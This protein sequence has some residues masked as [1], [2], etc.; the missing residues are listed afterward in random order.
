MI[1]ALFSIPA[2]FDSSMV[3]AF[4]MEPSSVFPRIFHTH[5]ILEGSRYYDRDGACSIIKSSMIKG[6][7]YEILN[8][9]ETKT[10]HVFPTFFAHPN[11]L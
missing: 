11:Q 6:V 9:I 4:C 5:R 7:M 8:G 1:R 3:F 10:T 2:R